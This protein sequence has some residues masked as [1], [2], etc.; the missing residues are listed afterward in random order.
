MVEIDTSTE[1]VG[2]QQ[3]RLRH[4]I[5]R[6]SRREDVGVLRIPPDAN[7]DADMICKEADNLL[8]ALAAERDDAKADYL[9]RHKEACAHYA[10]AIEAE[11]E[12]DRLAGENEQLRARLTESQTL[13][14]CL[15]EED[16]INVA[17]HAALQA[18]RDRLA[19]DVTRLKA[20][21]RALRDACEVRANREGGDFGPEI[22]P[23]IEEL[24]AALGDHD[25]E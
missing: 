14:R 18:D 1:A 23:H 17:E 4:V 24:N 8:R 25:S 16:A 2:Q 3:L 21:A 10:R 12:R 22:G 15:R 20:A 9:R 7:H 11:A 13:V 19:A 5:S 6:I